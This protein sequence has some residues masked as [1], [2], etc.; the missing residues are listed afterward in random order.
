M[1]LEYL[2]LVC[3]FLDMEAYNFI[4]GLNLMRPGFRRVVFSV[5]IMIIVLFFREG[6]M[7]ENE[8]NLAGFGKWLK[9]KFGKKTTSA[10]EAE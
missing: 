4:P 10:K 7:G 2:Y 5:A 1:Y 9:R 8:L 3:Q 6:I